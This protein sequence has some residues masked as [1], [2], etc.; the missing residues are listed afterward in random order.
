MKRKMSGGIR[1]DVNGGS[2]AFVKIFFFWAGGG[3]G[4]GG[5]V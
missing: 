5:G 3:G 2:E 1:V 4:G